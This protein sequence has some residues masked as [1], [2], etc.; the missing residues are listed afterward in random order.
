MCLCSMQLLNAYLEAGSKSIY[1]YLC[2]RRYYINSIE[3]VDHRLVSIASLHWLRHY[4][5]K[6]IKPGQEKQL[7]AGEKSY[8]INGNVMKILRAATY[9]HCSAWPV[10]SV[11]VC[12]SGQRCQNLLTSSVDRCIFIVVSHDSLLRLQQRLTGVVYR[13]WKNLYIPCRLLVIWNDV[14]L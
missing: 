2:S 9:D 6:I 13:E 11:V 3:H 7:T 8:Y 12:T 5:V 10:L 4:H 1:K 14:F